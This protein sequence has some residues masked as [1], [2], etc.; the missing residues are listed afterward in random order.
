MCEK[1]AIKIFKG[2]EKFERYLK[3]S[4]K[5]LSMF[6]NLTNKNVNVPKISK[7]YR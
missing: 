1:L 7:S 3:K 6:K 4:V 5:V 2:L